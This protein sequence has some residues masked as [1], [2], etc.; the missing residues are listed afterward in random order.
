[1]NS[2]K[3]INSNPLVLAQIMD[4]LKDKSETE[5]KLL[6]VRFFQRELQKE[7]KGITRKGGLKKNLRSRYHKSD[8]KKSLS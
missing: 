2:L 8:S 7:W 1:M 4:K 3:F 6:Y 5:L